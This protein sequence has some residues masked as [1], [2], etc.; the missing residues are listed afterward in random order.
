MWLTLL[1]VGPA[2]AF[3]WGDGCEFRADRAGGVDA[4]GIEKVGIRAGAGDM[5]VSGTVHFE[6][7]EGGVNVTA[8]V[9]G[10]TPDSEHGFH[11]HEKGDLSDPKL[12]SAGAH[13]NPTGHKHGGAEG[14]PNPMQGKGCTWAPSRAAQ[15]L[16]ATSPRGDIS[17]GTRSTATVG[18]GARIQGAGGCQPDDRR[19]ATHVPPSCACPNFPSCSRTS[20]VVGVRHAAPR[21]DA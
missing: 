7:A 18:C 4:A 14:E 6:E 3:A 9:S 21:G 11:I 16:Q 15:V 2:T 12:Q 1:A 8:D 13:F 17:G 20:R 5:K 10:L 19:C